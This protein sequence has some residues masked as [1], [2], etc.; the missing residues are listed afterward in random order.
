LF[1]RAER[2]NGAPEQIIAQCRSCG[3]GH[4]LGI[5]GRAVVEQRIKAV[6]L[7]AEQVIPILRRADIA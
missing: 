1:A 5:L 2:K 6:E 7:F 3:A 4:F